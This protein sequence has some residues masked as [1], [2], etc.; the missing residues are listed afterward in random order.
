MTRIRGLYAITDAG[1]LARGDY[2]ERAEQALRG[3]ARMLQYR[4]KGSDA[5]RRREQAR[6]L[7]A[8]CARYDVPLIV[9]D[10]PVL[11]A[12]TGAAG[13]HLGRDDTA[14]AHARTLLG[15][16]AI[17][18]VSCY[19]ELA[20]AQT[21]AA[22]GASYVA[23]GSFFLSLTKPGV[24]RAS[25]GLLAQAR[26]TLPVPIVAIGG[27]T[28]ENGAALVAAGADAL[29]VIEGVFG[30]PDIAAAARA[31]AALFKES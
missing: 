30:Q 4:S 18:G 6:A 16:A 22:A 23:F 13:V 28:P 1:G 31:Y 7:A 19:D 14:V 12:E 2:L 27:I 25:L 9:N 15:P 11:A 8:L 21:A 26:A 5:A 29:A 10:D 24:V 20:R 17:I 3:G